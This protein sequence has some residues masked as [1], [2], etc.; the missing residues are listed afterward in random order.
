MN[1]ILTD[2]GR[3]AFASYLKART[4][5]MA[6]GTG[7]EASD[8]NQT[9]TDV[10]SGGSLSVGYTNISALSLAPAAG[11]ANYVQGVD[12]SVNLVTGI[13]TA[14]SGGIGGTSVI[15]NFYVNPPTPL[16]SAT[17]LVGEVGRRL[18]TVVEYCTPD[19]AGTI[20]VDGTK[21]TASSDPTPYLHIGV[22]FAPSDAPSAVIKEYAIYSDGTT[23]PSLPGGQKYF[24]GGQI[25]ALGKL[26]T[27]RNIDTITRTSVASEKFD[28]VIPF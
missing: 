6:W 18:V 1:S 7:V 12:Y 25:L 8:T 16:Q 10:F 23:D 11:G 5:F 26:V 2:S 20:V 24:S 15:A 9:H 4:L 14:I 19:D 3:A 22:T 28:L 13:L 17:A 27:I 21:Y